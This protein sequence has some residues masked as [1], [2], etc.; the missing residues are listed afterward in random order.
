MI[1]LVTDITP[2]IRYT[3]E[4]IAKELTGGDVKF[5]TDRE[6]FAQLKIP[7][8]NY[9]REPI[10]SGEFFVMPHGLLSEE[11]IHDQQVACFETNGYKAFFRTEGDWPFDVFA[12]TFYLLSRYEEYLP[13]R[14]DE[15]GR[16]AHTESLAYRERFLDE[17]LINRWLIELR[18]AMTE[19]FSLPAKPASFLFLPTYDIDIAWSYRQKGWLRTTGAF[20]SDTLKGKFNL[21][22]E[23]WRVIRG[24][25]HSR[26][27]LG[28][29][30]TYRA[31]RRRRSLEIRSSRACRRPA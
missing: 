11:G 14:K 24:R 10:G 25:T 31:T 17:P 27:S 21:L 26:R 29:A 20:I 1:V 4:F 7:R 16:Y 12:A 22:W 9:T 18:R 5:T 8:I 15:Y 13:H 3:F 30:G 28:W 2:R 23:R 6:E 19:R